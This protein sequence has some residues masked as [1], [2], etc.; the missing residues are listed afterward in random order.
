MV[1][2]TVCSCEWFAV[3]GCRV[4]KQRDLYVGTVSDGRHSLSFV[5]LRFILIRRCFSW[6]SLLF[7]A[8]SG[9]LS[10]ASELRS[11][12]I[13]MLEQSLMGDKLAAE[14]LLCHLISSV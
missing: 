6:S 9:L 1:F 10:E 13:S 12:M 4:K 3:G 14:Y 2:L 8:V 11:N 7:V 5:T